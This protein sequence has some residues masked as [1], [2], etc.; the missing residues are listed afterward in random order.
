MLLRRAGIRVVDNQAI[1]NPDEEVVVI[2]ES[3]E[4]QDG[5]KTFDRNN[6][7]YT[8]N[9]WGKKNGSALEI[10]TLK[11]RV[12]HALTGGNVNPVHLYDVEG[13]IIDGVKAENSYTFKE[14][15][16]YSKKVHYYQ[17]SININ[18]LIRGK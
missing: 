4:N 9:M 14:I 7:S 2:M 5:T 12:L 17:S 16:G 8:I 18:F 6:V 11:N 10:K 1:S 3:N 13:Y 15:E